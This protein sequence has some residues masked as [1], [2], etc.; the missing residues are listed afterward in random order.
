MAGS[1]RSRGDPPD[2]QLRMVERDAVLRPLCAAGFVLAEFRPRRDGRSDRGRG[3]PAAAAGRRRSAG[4]EHPDRRGRDG[5]GQR[6]RTEHPVARRLPRRG[7]AAGRG[8][9]GRGCRRHPDQGRP[10]ARGGY[11]AGQP[12]IRPDREPVHRKPGAAGCSR[13]PRTGGLC[14]IRRTQP[15][16]RVRPDQPFDPDG[17]R[18]GHQP[19]TVVRVQ[20]G[21]RQFA[22]PHASAQPGCGPPDSAGGRGH[23]ARGPRNGDACTRPGAALCRVRRAAMV[24]RQDL[25]RLL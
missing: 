5:R 3:G 2:V 16:R 11:P 24:Q 18:T 22:K 17:V 8:G 15:V 1:E 4:R 19:R 13:H 6:R 21:R 23:H 14:A 12:A 7:C 20:D 10:A 9:L 25:G